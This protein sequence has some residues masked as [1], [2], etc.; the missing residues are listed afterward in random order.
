[1]SEIQKSGLSQA[2]RNCLTFQGFRTRADVAALSYA[3]LLRL[4]NIGK[5]RAAEIV[6]WVG[7]RMA[8]EARKH[9]D[10]EERLSRVTLAQRL[11]WA[12]RFL[13]QNGYRVLDGEKHHDRSAS[14]SD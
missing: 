14:A 3:E 7:G 6:E 12:K 13:S 10:E 2:T 9:A 8:E 5:G 4:S 11:A 1:M